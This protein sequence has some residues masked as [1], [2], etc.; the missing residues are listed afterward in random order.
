MSL[1]NIIVCQY[2]DFL[3]FVKVSKI[4]K[5]LSRALAKRFIRT[6]S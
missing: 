3:S 1:S 6:T 5:F 4:D 2:I